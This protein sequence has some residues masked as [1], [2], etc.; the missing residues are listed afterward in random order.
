MKVILSNQ[1]SDLKNLELYNRNSDKNFDISYSESNN[2]GMPE[3]NRL[4]IYSEETLDFNTEIDKKEIREFFNT[5]TKEEKHND[6]YYHIECG[7]LLNIEQKEEL[8]DNKNSM[9]YINSKKEKK[10]K[11]R[12][13]NLNNPI[14]SESRFANS[15]VIGEAATLSQTINS[16]L[17]LLE[18]V[19]CSA[20]FSWISASS[21]SSGILEKY[22]L[23]SIFALFIALVT[24]FKKEWSGVTA[25]L[26]SVFE[27]LTVG[28]ISRDFEMRYPRIV[29]QAVGKNA[30]IPNIEV[31][32]SVFDV[33]CGGVNHWIFK[34]EMC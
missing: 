27:G 16:C 2:I 25:P 3:N 28:A 17:I 21:R 4:N 18:L 33:F 30:N 31:C 6:I 32:E 11:L 9:N 15:V 26:Y 10:Q 29:F 24:C 34:K 19:V 1:K 8:I 23:F 5:T 13:F 22:F 7:R 14:L 20:E 12:I